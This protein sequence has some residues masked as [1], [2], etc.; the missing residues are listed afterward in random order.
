MASCPCLQ[1]E[2]FWGPPVRPSSGTFAQNGWSYPNICMY[3]SRTLR[4]LDPSATTPTPHLRI[5]CA[6]TVHATSWLDDILGGEEGCSFGSA[7]ALGRF[8]FQCVSVSSSCRMSMRFRR[9]LPI[10]SFRHTWHPAW[11]RS[12]GRWFQEPDPGIPDTP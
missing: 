7:V 11:G 12:V 6:K 5:R 4:L 3:Y 10:R 1:V 8:E 2:V 9:S